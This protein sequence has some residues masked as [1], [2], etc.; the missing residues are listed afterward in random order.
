MESQRSGSRP[1][2]Y[3]WKETEFSSIDETPR[4]RTQARRKG[5]RNAR[6]TPEFN[7]KATISARSA[8]D[9]A[10]GQ[11]KAAPPVGDLRREGVS[12]NSAT[13]GSGRGQL[14][15]SWTRHYPCKT[16]PGRL[17]PV[18]RPCDRN[19][20]QPDS[21]HRR[22]SITFDGTTCSTFS[23]FSPRRADRGTRIRS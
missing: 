13:V 16:F 5:E 23:F 20:G 8:T 1:V 4:R 7:V 3:A 14:K 18:G 12:K 11:S 22:E 21:I 6:R 10:P 17:S 2:K 19:S 9:S 15:E